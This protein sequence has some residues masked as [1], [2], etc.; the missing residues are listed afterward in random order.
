M[1]DQALRHHD[2][3]TISRRDVPDLAHMLAR[4]FD[5]DPVITWTLP[6]A[7][8][9]RTRAPLAFATYLQTYLPKGHV[10]ADHALRSAALW[11]PPG[12]W[13][14][15]FADIMRLLPT[16]ARTYGSR[17]PLLL[18]GFALLEHHHPD[19]IPHWY[20]SFVGTDPEHQGKG[21]GAA[22]IAPV[23]AHCDAHGEPVYLEATRPELVPFY[24]RHGF[25]VIQRF[26][27]LAGPS[28]WGMWREPQQ[29]EGAR[30]LLSSAQG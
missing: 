29:E 27:L 14:V 4:A 5:D 18:A 6:D 28:V 16:L 3:R 19:H 12:T 13:R 8:R 11:A 9:R 20:L 24:R 25:V 26:D 30:D 10:Y 21:L 2:V 1:S 23:L 17:L 7:H 22:V 15:G